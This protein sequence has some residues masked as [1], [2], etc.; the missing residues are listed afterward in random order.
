MG[1]PK[2]W[3]ESIINMHAFLTPYPR[4]LLIK[5]LKWPH[6]SHKNKKIKKKNT[7]WEC[8]KLSCKNSWSKTG[9]SRKDKHKV[10]QAQACVLLQLRK[11]IC[12]T[13][14]SL[15]VTSPPLQPTFTHK[16]QTTKKSTGS[17]A[18]KESAAW[19]KSMTEN[20]GGREKEGVL[21]RRREWNRFKTVRT[22]GIYEHMETAARAG[23]KTW[24]SRRLCQLYGNTQVQM[25]IFFHFYRSSLLNSCRIW[26]SVITCCF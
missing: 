11:L 1:S 16:F 10:Q 2:R 8:G 7:C 18:E 26:N 21:L 24:N 15:V 23:T 19:K 3:R 4:K 9:I 17:L 6:F 14:R 20:C 5:T 22:A 13:T 12:W 25:N